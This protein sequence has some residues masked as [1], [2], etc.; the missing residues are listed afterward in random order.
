MNISVCIPTYNRAQLLSELFDSLLKAGGQSIEVVVSDN[1]STDSTYE[2][3]EKYK[4]KFSNLIYWQWE[5]NEGPDKNF[6]KCVELATRD[7]CWLM[8]S[9]DSIT[10]DAF[11]I[12]TSTIISRPDILLLNMLECDGNMLPHGKHYWLGSETP[13]SIYNGNNEAEIINFFDSA[14]PLW[15]LF[16]GYISS[17]CV[18][19]EAWQDICYDERYTGSLFSFTSVVLQ[20]F[21]SGG[22]LAYIKHP[23]VMNRGHNDSIIAEMGA[24]GLKKRFSHDLE[25]YIEFSKL[26]NSSKIR[27]AYLDIARRNYSWF[28]LLKIRTYLT[29]SE[30]L[31]KCTQLREVGVNNALLSF[32][33]VVGV[34]SPLLRSLFALKMQLF[35][36]Q[37]LLSK[38]FY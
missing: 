8:G 36:K 26:A 7:Y 31:E 29:K 32:I 17:I 18:R 20:M 23:I 15:G 14:R 1:A 10:I 38:K 34:A 27:K 13:D 33:S 21:Y 37:R 22:H 28:P 25:W 16:L 35:P 30:W 5:K 12:V 4:D 19:R 3:I 9:D 6:L 2:V 24:E 11:D